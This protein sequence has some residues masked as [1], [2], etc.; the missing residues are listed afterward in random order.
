MKW[1]VS[2]G[3]HGCVAYRRCT[4][5]LSGSIYVG[6]LLSTMSEAQPEAIV[7]YIMLSDVPSIVGLYNSRTIVHS[8]V[9]RWSSV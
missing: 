6:Y 4:L 9:Q 3:G 2:S 1:G 7:S 5:V 8:G